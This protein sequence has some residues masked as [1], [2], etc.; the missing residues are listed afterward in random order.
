MSDLFMG[1]VWV[2]PRASNGR[3]N[4]HFIADVGQVWCYYPGI[5]FTVSSHSQSVCPWSHPQGMCC[6]V[7]V[8]DSMGRSFHVVG[9]RCLPNLVW[10]YIFTL[11]T[12]WSITE[13][14]GQEGAGTIPGV[15]SEYVSSWRA[16]GDSG[17]V[18]SSPTRLARSDRSLL[19][20]PLLPVGWSLV[21][22]QK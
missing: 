12:V 4:E 16:P 3:Q 2:W 18:S 6:Q 11:T 20:R 8:G 10:S 17:T 13:C 19:C 7:P 1:S 22:L 15:R 5:A 9:H 14:T 21:A